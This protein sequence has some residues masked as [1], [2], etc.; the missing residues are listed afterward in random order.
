M[1]TSIE[2]LMSVPVC[3]HPRSG[4]I[5]DYENANHAY[6]ELDVLVL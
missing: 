2:F 5:G 6:V 4:Y 3:V 1:G